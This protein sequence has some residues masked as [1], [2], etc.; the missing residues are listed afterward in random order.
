[1]STI[2]LQHIPVYDVRFSL[3]T[4]FY[5]VL[6]PGGLLKFQMGYGDNLKDNMGRK[7][8]HYFD[9]A[10]ITEGSNGTYDVRVTNKNHLINDLK[11]IGFKNILINIDKSFCDFGHDFWIYVSAEK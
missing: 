7:K 6:N 9:N 8:A 1:M 10:D 2:V 11:S 5:R 4:E 3:L